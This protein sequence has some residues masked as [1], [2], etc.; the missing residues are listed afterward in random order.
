MLLRIGRWERGEESV[1]S[2]NEHSMRTSYGDVLALVWWKDERML[3]AL[4]EFE[5]RQASRRS[6]DWS[7]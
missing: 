2:D 5:E 1:S 7:R 3:I 4:D 6:D